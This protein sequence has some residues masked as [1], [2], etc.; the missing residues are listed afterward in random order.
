MVTSTSEF[1]AS[2]F[3]TLWLSYDTYTDTIQIIN[4]NNNKLYCS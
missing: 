4:N 2:G 1:I 3:G